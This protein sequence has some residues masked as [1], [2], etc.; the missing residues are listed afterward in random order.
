LAIQ[1]RWSFWTCKIASYYSFLNTDP[2]P[3]K[4]DGWLSV[5]WFWRFGFVF[6]NTSSAAPS[7]APRMSSTRHRLQKGQLKRGIY[8]VRHFCQ[9]RP[10]HI[11]WISAVRQGCQIFLDTMHQNWG[12]YTILPLN[13][14]NDHQMHQKA[15]IYS[16]WNKNITTF[17]NPW[18]AKIDSN[19]DFWFENIPSGNPAVRH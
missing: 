17:T 1:H 2:A 3:R 7:I 13:Y 4:W 10:R 14:Q 16:K 5:L 18:P 11:K 15:V 9:I 12:N 6:S 8:A 19:C